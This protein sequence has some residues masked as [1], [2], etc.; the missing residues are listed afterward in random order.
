MTKPKKEIKPGRGWALVADNK[1]LYYSAKDFEPGD[2]FTKVKAVI[3]EAGAARRLLA[4]AKAYRE[5]KK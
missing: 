1:L 5:R 4:D 2:G 3:I